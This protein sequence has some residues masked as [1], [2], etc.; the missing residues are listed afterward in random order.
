[1]A[2][3]AF[4]IVAGALS[5]AAL[6]NN[7]VTCFE[8]LE[9]G[10]QFGQDVERC[11]LRVDI[12]QTRLSR[13][14]EAVAINEDPR[15]R[16]AAPTDASIRQVQSIL[17]E[18]GL[19]FQ[20]VQK[21]SAR[22]TL[23]AKPEDQAPF[24]PQDMRPAFQQLHGRLLRAVRQR[25][26]QTSLGK[27][28]AWALYDGRNLDRLIDQIAS[29]LNDLE[30]IWPVEPACRQLAQRDLEG[31]HDGPDLEAVATAATRVDSV[32]ADLATQKL[33]AIAVKNHAGPIVTRERARVQVGNEFADNPFGGNEG[34]SERTMNTTENVT[35]SGESTVQVGNRYG[36]RGILDN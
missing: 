28:I 21:R 14:G 1:M 29:F 8:Y 5:V 2:A 30:K 33:N 27:K 23:G 31:I 16:T 4:G 19:L 20:S 12:A 36:D 17:E 26:K 32:V 9:L 15:F 13:W 34:I 24:Q 11:Q 18:I 7:C 22:Y 10:R 6:F 3:E 35:A 25:Q